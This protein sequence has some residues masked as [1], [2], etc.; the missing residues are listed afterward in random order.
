[1]GW[2][3]GQDLNLHAWPASVLK[4][5]ASTIPPPGPTAAY[6]IVRHECQD[7]RHARALQQDLAVDTAAAVVRPRPRQVP[8]RSTAALLLAYAPGSQRGQ[9]SMPAREDRPPNPG[10]PAK[11]LSRPRAKDDPE[12]GK[13]SQREKFIQTAHEL[14]CEESGDKLDEALRAISKARR[15]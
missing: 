1:M 8:D 3:P 15:T 14:G 5:A 13:L 2:C 7:M 9:I 4:T 6:G 12:W 10:D 11:P